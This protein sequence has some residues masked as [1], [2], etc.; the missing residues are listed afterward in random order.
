MSDV[1]ALVDLQENSQLIWMPVPDIEFTLEPFLP[2]DPEELMSS[3]Q[4]N[5]E[6]GKP[7]FWFKIL[8]QDH[9]QFKVIPNEC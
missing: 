1:L 6:I 7:I 8:P 5:K 2:G 4:F 3:G 9:L